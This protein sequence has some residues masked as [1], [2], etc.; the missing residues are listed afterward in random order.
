MQETGGPIETIGKGKTVIE[1]SAKGKGWTT[2]VSSAFVLPSKTNAQRRTEKVFLKLIIKIT[3]YY[4][5]MQSGN[6]AV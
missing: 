2:R 1:G 6:P 3:T 5:S 4:H